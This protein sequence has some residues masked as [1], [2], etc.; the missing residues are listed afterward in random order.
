MTNLK[1]TVRTIAIESYK[2]VAELLKKLGAGKLPFFRS[3]SQ[4]FYHLLT[5]KSVNLDGFTIY[6]DST[7]SLGLSVYGKYE[8]LEIETIKKEIPE[9]SVF[10]DIGANIGYHTLQIARHVGKNG[11]VYAFEPDEELF[12]LLKKNIIINNIT[13]VTL[14]K[15]AASDKVGNAK[16]YLSETNKADYKIYETNE[17]RKSITIDTTTLDNYFFNYRGSIDL[18]K[19]DIQGSE[20][21]AFEGMINTLK[22][23]HNIKIVMEYWPAAIKSCGNDPEKFLDEL[24]S[25]GFSFYDLN[26]AAKEVKPIDKATILEKYNTESDIYTNLLCKR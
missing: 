4:F 6:L 2:L 21:L 17:R 19:M 16:L 9:G 11:H 18:I 13:N 20:Y 1:K 25:L 10:V 15:K 14:V 8:P 23:Y 12:S 5:T 3:A 7:D 26:E 22:K 24:N